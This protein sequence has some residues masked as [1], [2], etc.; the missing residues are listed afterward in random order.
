MNLNYM[1]LFQNIMRPY[2]EVGAGPTTWL[3]AVLP[4]S[5]EKGLQYLCQRR[6]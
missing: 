2:N 3:K 1:I 6:G 4:E 5:T